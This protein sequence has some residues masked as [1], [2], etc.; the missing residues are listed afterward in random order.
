MFS[1]LFFP[2]ILIPTQNQDKRE[3]RQGNGALKGSNVTEIILQHLSN[4][5]SENSHQ[6]I[7]N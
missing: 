2:I 1:F 5:A 6:S 4:N 7:A 3:H